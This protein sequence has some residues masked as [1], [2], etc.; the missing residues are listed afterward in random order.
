MN[1]GGVKKRRRGDEDEAMVE[2]SSFAGRATEYAGPT[3]SYSEMIRHQ[4]HLPP[5]HER[6]AF[7][8]RGPPLNGDQIN[9]IFLRPRRQQPSGDSMQAKVS[10]LVAAGSSEER[11][12]EVEWV[13]D[14]L[15][16]QPGGGHRSAVSGATQKGED[17]QR[18]AFEHRGPHLHGDQ[19]KEI[20][21]PSRREQPSGDFMQVN[22]TSSCETLRGE[23][24]GEGGRLHSAAA[25]R[26]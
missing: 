26:W 21:C 6:Q 10:R 24:G 23:G 19:N 22:A 2:L 18:Q 11:E 1:E 4:D 9:R 15:Q 13:N 25:E 14:F 8:Y 5:R 12:N 16:Q 3:A 17:C 20:S 7:W